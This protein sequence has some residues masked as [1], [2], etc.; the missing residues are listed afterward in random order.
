MFRVYTR[1]SK[2]PNCRLTRPRATSR[3]NREKSAAFVARVSPLSP[4]W[5]CSCT[6]T[7]LWNDWLGFLVPLPSGLPTCYEA[8]SSQP[9]ITPSG[10][11][12][13]YP[14]STP[15]KSERSRLLRGRQKINIITN[16]EYSVR[17]FADDSIKHRSNMTTISNWFR[18]SISA[19]RS[20][21]VS[22]SRG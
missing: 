3:A 4:H 18:E 2:K 1:H 15:A 6:Q 21:M 7:T 20:A 5:M 11:E 13:P 12:L 10:S 14:P 17:Q 9:L 8:R 22:Q 16:S 19:S